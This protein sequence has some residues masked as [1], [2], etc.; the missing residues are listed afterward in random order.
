[1]TCQVP[2]NH[3]IEGALKVLLDEVVAN[4]VGTLSVIIE[5]GGGPFDAVDDG[6]F[7][8]ILACPQSRGRTRLRFLFL[9]NSDRCRYGSALDCWQFLTCYLRVSHTMNKVPPAPLLIFFETMIL[10]T[11]NFQIQKVFVEQLTV[12]PTRC[13]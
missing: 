13:F 11:Q 8:D 5:A 10:T 6:S 12:V 7:S 9:S 4:V 1:M 3:G 2:R